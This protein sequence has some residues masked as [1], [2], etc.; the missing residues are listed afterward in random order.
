[1]GGSERCYLSNSLI[2]NHTTPGKT[3][4]STS[5]VKS[6]GGIAVW[7]YSDEFLSLKVATVG[8]F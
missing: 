6:N 4:Q 7:L 2:S 3:G 8:E 1:M 5:S